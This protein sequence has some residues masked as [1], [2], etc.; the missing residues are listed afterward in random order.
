MRIYQI[1]E[2]IKL[3]RNM[4]QVVFFHSHSLISATLALMIKKLF[5]FLFISSITAS[6]SAQLESKAQSF[7]SPRYTF[8]IPGG[9]MSDRFGLNSSL[10]LTFATKKENG[11]YFGVNG[12]YQFGSD[13]KEPGLIQ[14]LLSVN[15]EI[16]S[17][18]G[19]PASVLIQQRGFNF[20]VDFG[21]F[22]R[23][24]NSKNESGILFTIGTGFIQHNIRF[25]HQLDDIPQLDGE[26][27]KGYD[28]LSNGLMLS[29]NIGWLFF[30]KKRFGDFYLGLELIE[31]ITSSRREYN[32]D[33][34]T[35]DLGDTRLDLLFGIKAGWAVP[36]YKK[37]LYD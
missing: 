11:N 17:V 8:Q 6:V 13:V 20:S 27:E 15:D 7:F 9:D 1:Y 21:K 31:A 36:F 37:N 2:E 14:N 10:G 29:Q 16:I 4:L 18:E 28:R 22:M 25:E 33:T 3:L 19:K 26:Y 5:L 35:S 34:S 24:T 12:N 30:S 23:F 32:F